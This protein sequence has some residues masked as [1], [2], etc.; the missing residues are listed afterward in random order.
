[1]LA[2]SKTTIKQITTSPRIAIVIPVFK[3]SV[4]VAEAITCAIEQDT[5]FPYV[6]VIVND[7]CKF[8]ETDRVARD[9]AIAY[10][11]KVT[12]LYRPNGG[13]S[14]ARNTGID[15]ALTTWDSVEAIYLLDA[16]NRIAPQT[17]ERSFQ[18]L[19][20]ESEV[21]WVY[22]T[23]NMFGQEDNGEYRGDYSVLRH[24][25]FNT[26]EAG[27]M[28]RREV[29]EQGCRYDESMKL[30]FEDWEFWWQAVEAGYRGKHLPDL[31][32]QYRKRPE[33]MLRNSERD[34]E[35]IVQYMKRKHRQ[36]FTHSS[37]I[38]LEHRE[39]PRY[40]IFIEETAEF[41][42]TSDPV[43]LD[44]SVSAQEF[45]QIYLQAKSAPLRYHRP[46]FLIFTRKTVLDS[47]EEHKLLRWAFWQLE[48]SS[49]SSNFASLSLNLNSE[50]KEIIFHDNEP[51]VER[52]L[53]NTAHLVMTTVN[54]LDSCIDDSGEDWIQSLASFHPMPKI[55]HLEV[56]I[57]NSE[58]GTTSSGGAV[59]RYGGAVL[60][61]LSVFGDLRL[62]SQKSDHKKWT[63]QS[64]YF[65]ARSHMFEEARWSL[66]SKPIYPMLNQ[67]RKKHIGFV[68]PIVEFG[69]VE[70]VALNI[71]KVFHDSGWNI[72]LFVLNPRMQPL[73]A[74]A[75][76]FKTVNFLHEPS[77]YHW[78]GPKYLGSRYDYWSQ[79]GNHEV[80]AG[81]LSWLDVVINFHSV[82][83]NGVM[84][85]LR[86]AGVKTVASLHVHDL[87][88]SGRANGFSHLTLGYEHAYDYMIPCSYQMADW[89]HGLGVPEDKLV[90]VPNACGYP[91]TAAEVEQIL[92]RRRARGFTGKLRVLFIG[93]FDRQK[94]LDRL[95][96]IVTKSRRLGLPIHW[97]L[98]GKNVVK[99]ENAA[100]E[101]KSI[102]DLIEPPALT[103]EALNQLYEW[104]DVLL[105]PSYWE[106]LPLT[107][108]E[109]M[110]LGVVVCAS[111]VGAVAEAIDKKTG[112]VIPNL[113]GDAYVDAAIDS[114][115]QLLDQPDK[116]RAISQAA[117][118]I[119]SKRS[120]IKACS[121]LLNKFV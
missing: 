92:D 70:K 80:A 51:E 40:A 99:G 50:Q 20:A 72:H 111:N 18:A 37:I 94:G 73:P 49:D 39:A 77:M 100:S 96:G 101:L 121:N 103:T 56:E 27:S 116:L 107:I 57:P 93:R 71:A 115:S 108:L 75:N 38:E 97:R 32:F 81:L 9:F 119:A 114:L 16:D 11:D 46:H 76:S 17:I 48:L 3:H 30:G 84:G 43:N 112:L 36:L 41:I 24:L 68:L 15:F 4:L 1:M 35:G 109:A 44:K 29:L 74:W 98:V 45:R 42:L 63:W 2:T 22:P 62:S 66:N 12:Y 102:E 88:P 86:R 79:S 26:C 52:K 87:T 61:L 14:A 55:H 110:R 28:V 69:G 120:W 53:A 21:G 7:G 104:A 85:L 6:I 8:E 34:R 5:K 54:T 113:A 67:S 90:V 89:C 23:I 118:T 95:V 33:S 82:A 25:R 106:G 19:F 60:S 78:H 47:L 117:A 91:L 58:S 83:V 65:P 31:G 10:P 64:E 13:L 59:L 105:L